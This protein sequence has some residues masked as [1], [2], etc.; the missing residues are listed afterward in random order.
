M[1]AAVGRAHEGPSTPNEFYYVYISEGPSVS[2]LEI[3][4]SQ[5][6][7]LPQIIFAFSSF[8]TNL[9]GPNEDDGSSLPVENAEAIAA[10]KGELVGPTFTCTFSSF[11]TEIA[12][13][14]GCIIPNN[15]A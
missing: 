2:S 5:A 3:H 15:M 6:K 9:Q 14:Y 11:G 4:E 1:A 7:G 12:G 8:G 10:A 13:K